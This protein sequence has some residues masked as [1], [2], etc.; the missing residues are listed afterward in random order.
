MVNVT[1][2]LGAIELAWTD[3]NQTAG[4]Q[5]KKTA[6]VGHVGKRSQRNVPEGTVNGSAGARTARKHRET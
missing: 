6:S 3:T 1:N 5:Q 2:S 4:D